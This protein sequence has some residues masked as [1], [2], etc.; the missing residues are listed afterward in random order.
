[1]VTDAEGNLGSALHLRDEASKGSSGR[2]IPFN[3]DLRNAL[4][5]LHDERDSS[6]YVIT[7]E[8]AGRTSAAASWRVTQRRS[9][10]CWTSSVEHDPTLHRSGCGST[11]TGGWFGLKL[12]DFGAKWAECLSRWT[13]SI[14]NR[15][16]AGHRNRAPRQANRANKGIRRRIVCV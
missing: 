13:R 15:A 7:T 2:V 9:D 6:P 4:Q 14:R 8:R 5:K 3:K 12:S 10:A 16:F 11:E 1:M